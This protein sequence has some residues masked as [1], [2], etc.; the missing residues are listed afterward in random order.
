MKLLK[1][2]KGKFKKGDL[3]ISASGVLKSALTVNELKISEIYPDTIVNEAGGVICQPDE[4]T[5]EIV[6]AKKVI[7]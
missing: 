5:G 3:F 2:A 6:W 7:H 4:V 1:E